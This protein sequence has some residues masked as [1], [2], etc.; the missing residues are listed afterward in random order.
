MIFIKIFIKIVKFMVPGL[1]IQ[2]LGRSQFSHIVKLYLIVS[3]HIYIC[4][5]LNALLWNSGSTRPELW[6]LGAQCLEFRP[7]GG[8]AIY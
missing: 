7:K 5:E 4:G 2:D 3:T 6:N 1:A 8:I